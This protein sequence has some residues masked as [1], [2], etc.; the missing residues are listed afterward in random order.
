M[1]GRFVM[2]LRKARALL[3]SEAA[4]SGR[5]A[6]WEPGP[7]HWDRDTQRQTS[8]GERVVTQRGQ[9]MSRAL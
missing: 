2:F 1:S 3:G 8:G 9:G 5:E 4:L 6:G 7:G